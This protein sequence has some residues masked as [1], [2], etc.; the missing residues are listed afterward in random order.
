MIQHSICWTP[1]AADLE[2]SQIL[3]FQKACE[4]EFGL[5]FSN[6][7]EFQKWT[8]KEK[9]KFWQKWAVASAL[10]FEGSIEKVYEPSPQ[11]DFLGGHWFPDLRL[12]Y[13]ENLIENFHSHAPMLIGVVEG[14]KKKQFFKNEVKAKVARLQRYLKTECGIQ[15]GSVVGAFVPNCPETVICMLAVTGL[16]GIWSSCSTDFGEQGVLDRFEQIRPQVLFVADQVQYAGKIFDLAQKNEKIAQELAQRGAPLRKVLTIPH[17]GKETDLAKIWNGPDEGNPEYLRMPFE[18]PLFIMFS[19]GTTGKPKCIVHGVGGT[20]IQHLKEHKLH[21]D[22]RAGDRLLYYTTCGWM[23][24]NWL[25]SALASSVSIVCFDGSPAYPKASAIWRVVDEEK[26]NVFGTS[27]KFIGACRVTKLKLSGEFAFHHLRLVCSTGSPLLP[28]DFDYFYE[29]VV[30]LERPIP[31][32]SISG[33]TDILSCFMLGVPTK[34]VRRGEIQGFGLGMDVRALSPSG[35]PVVGEEGELVCGTPFPSMPVSFFNDP[36]CAKYRASYFDKIPGLWHHG[37][38][39]T[40]TEHRG[41]IVHGRSDATLNPGGVRIGTA[42]IYSQVETHPAVQDSLVVGRPNRRGDDEEIV[43]FVK[44]KSGERFSREFVQDLKNKIKTSA[45]PRHVPS[46]VFEVNE[47]PY[48]VS[49]KKVEIA[50]KKILQGRDPGN[51]DALS[52]PAALDEYE[53]FKN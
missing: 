9:E 50:V 36:D 48:T 21:C 5:K 52:N 43:L 13:A 1:A 41:V 25:V 29:R 18:S 6:Y 3:H 38:Y 22:L 2:S 19:S 37:D 35:H 40:V 32:A 20:L 33:G 30:H 12:N 10:I 53:K 23:M 26:I 15:K 45:S 51:R 47:I 27:A 34:P 8:V 49:G 31:I 39:I 24:W 46:Q 16:G 11:G 4:Q 42:E 44:L 17:W 28:E 14:G 7:E